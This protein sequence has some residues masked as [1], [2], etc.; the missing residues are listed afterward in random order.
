MFDDLNNKSFYQ[1]LELKK[2]WN[3][4][5]FIFEIELEILFNNENILEIKS[6]YKSYNSKVPEIF[7]TLDAIKLDEGYFIKCNNNEK[8]IL[9]GTYYKNITYKLNKGWNL[10]GYPLENLTNLE[11]LDEN[12]TEVKSINRNFNRK[13]INFSNLKELSNTSAYWL[14]SENDIILTI[15]NDLVETYD[16]VIV[17]SGPA[18]SM[19]SNI[20][21]QSEKYKN[22]K[23]A[24][25]EKGSYNI[26]SHFDTKY[27]NL[28]NWYGAM[29]D[30]N[31][32]NSYQSN[33][34]KLIWL[35][36]GLGGGT[37]HFGMFYIDNKDL[38]DHIPE[39]RLYLDKVNEITKTEGFNYNLNDI[40]L[41]TDIYNKFSN[42]SNIKFYNHK[43]YSDDIKNLHR[44]IA[45]DLLKN[46]N[47]DI[48]TNANVL[49]IKFDNNKATE[50]ILEN[51]KIIKFNQLILASG[52]IGNVK[53]LHNSNNE[54]L[55]NL[56]IGNTI[57]DHAGINLYYQPN[58]NFKNYI[59]VGHLQVR[60]KDLKTQVYF[61]KIAGVP[62]LV[63]S[64]SQAKK[65]SNSGLVDFKNNQRN[66]ILNHYT[67]S[68]KPKEIVDMY[69]Y[70]NEK[71]MEIGFQNSDPRPIT[72]EFVME[73]S[74]SIYHYH[75]T[76]PFNK[77]V[78]KTCKIIGIDNV[79]IGDISILNK[80]V[81]GST[82]VS[83]MTTGY[84]LAK[85]LLD[86]S[87][88]SKENE[89]IQLQNK[90]N[91]L[92]QEQEKLFSEEKLRKLWNDENKMYVVIQNDGTRIGSGENVV[93]DMGNFWKGGGH[94][95][96]LTSY[97]E[98]EKYNFT[99]I[100]RNRHGTFSAWRI[101]RG[102]ATEVGYFDDGSIDKEIN[103]LSDKINKLIE[104][105]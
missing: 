81:P 2:G 71:L 88:V 68:D 57:F 10:I 18:G 16:L 32:S 30:T 20:L 79:Y 59:N 56:P 83:S 77:V 52:A 75:G 72:K 29:T 23:I 89:I 102:G 45:S 103:E 26:K 87:F 11:E 48:K 66:I 54:I 22:K 6:L 43:V 1:T 51:N 31:N 84:R 37:L 104:N 17:G 74:D 85:I 92:K 97:L 14:F 78:D 42:D 90:I 34:D 94:P 50:V 70:I 8:I 49:E 21:S 55:Q 86:D 40:K 67:D 101:S 80:S 36:E 12:I 64:I 62:V 27:R 63:V 98:K 105:M 99:N 93:Y 25:L 9:E 69:N 47:I 28:L 13:L 19:I 35:G 5:S 7:N 4:V 76:C 82:S 3:F 61:N 58:D 96:N 73:N 38:F 100:L 15:E 24:V 39:I 46:L 44:F 60:S 95:V 33:N 53:I 65:E 41:W 91:K